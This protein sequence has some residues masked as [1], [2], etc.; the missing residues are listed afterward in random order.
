M[1]RKAL[2]KQAPQ[3]ASAITEPDHLRCPDD[4]LAERFEPQ[5][6]L[7]HLNVTQDCHQ[8]ALLQP[9]HALV[10]PRAMLAQ[11]GQHTHFDLAPADLPPW[12]TAIGSK[13]HHH[14]ISPKG[15]GQDRLLGCQ[16]LGRRAVI[17]R[18]GG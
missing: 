12:A 1:T 14:A 4:A 13:R 15:Q 11:T 10:G 7:E 2:L 3:P 9:R 17:S 5:T 18:D 6:W 16:W 8:A